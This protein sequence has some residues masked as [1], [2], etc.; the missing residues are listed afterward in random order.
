MA[1]G[2]DLHLT[3]DAAIA[4]TA[5]YADDA[6]VGLADATPNLVILTRINASD[7]AVLG[8]TDAVA[9]LFNSAEGIPLHATDT[10]QLVVVATASD[11]LSLTGSDLPSIVVTQTVTDA[12]TLGLT[13]ASPAMPLLIPVNDS[14]Q[15]VATEGVPTLDTDIASTAFVTATESV[16][17]GL[18]DTPSSSVLAT[19]ASD[20]VAFRIPD[21]GIYEDV[22]IF[23]SVP[24]QFVSVSVVDACVVQVTTTPAN[25]VAIAAS[26]SL[27]LSIVE[28]RDNM[29]FGNLSD[30]LRGGLS[31]SSSVNTGVPPMF[32]LSTSDSA[33]V[34]GAEG[35]PA[36]AVLTFITVTASDDVAY[37][38]SEATPN[39]IGSAQFAV[40]DSLRLMESDTARAAAAILSATDAFAI[41]AVEP[42]GLFSSWGA[43]DSLLV[44]SAEVAP[45]I[46][47]S[48]SFNTTDSAT[49]QAT[50]SA[51]TFLLNQ[52]VAVTDSLAGQAS[53]GGQLIAVAARAAETLGIT[54]NEAAS[55]LLKFMLITDSLG[56]AASDAASLFN[57]FIQLSASDANTIGQSELVTA[58]DQLLTQLSTTDTASLEQQDDLLIN[59][60]VS[61]SDA[62]ATT[63]LETLSLS[64]TYALQ[65]SLGFVAQA[66]NANVI[67]PFVINV[68]VFADDTT[69]ITSTDDAAVPDQ[70]LMLVVTD[71]CAVETDDLSLSE[72]RPLPDIWDAHQ[73]VSYDTLMPDPVSY[74][75][76]PQKTW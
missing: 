5:A 38:G 45:T 24:Q 75:M 41:Q 68:F 34:Q 67:N 73:G 23:G 26:D 56:I 46:A 28:P 29:T 54:V 70:L 22:Y 10:A 20:T 62:L 60:A 2:I 30:S 72:D 4:S 58:L 31:E 1:V 8:A 27:I 39:V 12:L 51:P 76:D 43:T 35:A 63:L 53:E 15:A 19:S 61:A 33:A 55:L 32:V 50:E 64:L 16:R 44:Q 49:F 74:R 66:E 7:S 47:G 21:V 52:P 3:D 59:S 40:A 11:S 42:S 57:T 18:T 36:F 37:A 14:L 71:D 6:S 48:F 17:T 9:G 13:D 65:D 69:A 25:Q